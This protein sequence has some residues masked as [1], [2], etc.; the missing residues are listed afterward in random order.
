MSRNLYGRRI[1][2][3]QIC[4]RRPEAEKQQAQKTEFEDGTEIGKRPMVPEQS[5]LGRRWRK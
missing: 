4:G 5:Q 3:I 1:P 2:A